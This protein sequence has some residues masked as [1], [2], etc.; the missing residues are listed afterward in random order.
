MT[1]QAGAIDPS[2]T[3]ASWSGA[4]EDPAQGGGAVAESLASH[5]R[6]REVPA[7][8]PASLFSVTR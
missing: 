8:G 4:L 2:V 3:S 7:D 5:A 1:S 6:E